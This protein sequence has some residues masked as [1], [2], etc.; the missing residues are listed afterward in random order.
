MMKNS[1]KRLLKRILS[2]VLV[3]ALS[4]TLVQIPAGSKAE[5]DTITHSED[6]D[7]VTIGNKY[8]TLSV[9]KNTGGFTLKTVEGDVLTKTDNNKRLLFSSEGDDT[10]FATVHIDGEDYV[11]GN[12]D[13]G[14]EFVEIPKI[15]DNTIVSS[16]E[17][18]AKNVL[19]TQT[20]RLL[21]DSKEDKLGSV[22]ISY[23]LATIDGEII[24]LLLAPIFIITGAIDVS[25]IT[26][27]VSKAKKETPSPSPSPSTSVP[28]TTPPTT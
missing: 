11:Y 9:S 12:E 20:I 26:L 18:K 1:N 15:V 21:M 5:A 19:V 10:S 13:D 24:V 17:V 22:Q 28:P 27:T 16:W 2:F 3:I 4:V 23:D 8:V 6:D 7:A 25:T 14:N